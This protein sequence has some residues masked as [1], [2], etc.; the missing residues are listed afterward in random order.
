MTTHAY[1]ITLNDSE[2]IAVEHALKHYQAMCENE[3]R[4]GPKAPYWAHLQSIIAVLRRLHADAQM[5]STSSHPAP[6]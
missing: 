5:T 3:L 2:V 4:T 6:S 1:R